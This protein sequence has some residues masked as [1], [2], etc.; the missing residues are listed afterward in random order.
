MSPSQASSDD[1]PRFIGAENFDVWKTRECA[2]LDGKHFLGYVKKPDYDSISDDESDESKSDMSDVDDS[3]K[4]KT[5]P[6]ENAEIDPDTIDDEASDDEP[7]PSSDSDDE[8]G[9]TLK[10]RRYG[11]NF[12]S[13]RDHRRQE[14]KTKAFLM[15][16]MDNTHV[17]LVKN[18]KSCYDIFQ[19][20]CQ[21]YEGAAFHGDPYF[22]QHYLMD[23]KYEEGS[24]LTDFFLN[25]ENAMKA[26]QEV[27][28][29]VMT[30]GQNSIYLFHSMPRSWKDD[31]HIW[32]GRRKY[33][34]YEDLK[35]SIEGKIRD[36]LAQE[37]Y[38]L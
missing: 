19:Y 34:P 15:K 13:Q 33:I 4:A 37:R 3:P 29:L 23:L 14:A 38:T 31:L 18:L 9:T 28:N 35:Q 6:K 26:A 11:R 16:S 8:S 10:P 2:A 30:E 24:D 32:K 25:L 7:K 12:P 20:I 21:K 5:N 22:I 17:R 36:T 27:T 1:F